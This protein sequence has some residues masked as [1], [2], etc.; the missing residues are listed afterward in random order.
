MINNS[1]NK[2]SKDSILDQTCSIT[3]I[4]TVIMNAAP[5]KRDIHLKRVLSIGKSPN[6]SEYEQNNSEVINKISVVNAIQSVISDMER[7][8]CTILTL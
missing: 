6:C 3:R 1:I 8:T 2:R 4:K 7:G 5:R